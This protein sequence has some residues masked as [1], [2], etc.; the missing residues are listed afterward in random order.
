[1]SGFPNIS[2]RLHRRPRK[3]RPNE[4]VSRSWGAPAW[5]H[6]LALSL[7]LSLLV[8]V[9]PALGASMARPVKIGWLS[10]FSIS[11]PMSL[12]MVDG[13]EKLGYRK[14]D[15]FVLGTISVDER[16][17]ELPGAAR[18]LIQLA[19]DILVG[20]NIAAAALLGMSPRQPIFFVVPFDPVQAGLVPSYNRPGGKVTGVALLHTALIPKSLE[21]FLALVPGMKRVLVPYDK[22][23]MEERT[24]V[25]RQS[26]HAQARTAGVEL[27]FLPLGSVAQAREALKELKGY[28]V[29]GVLTLS[30]IHFNEALVVES[31][32]REKIPM[33][34]QTNFF[35]ERGALAHYGAD[36]YGAGRQLA[37]LVGKV[38][39]GEDLANI[40]VEVHN[41]VQF[42]VN[43]RTAKRL[44]IK[45]PPRVLYR[46][47][48][49]IR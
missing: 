25:T 45:I 31:A 36:L 44:G 42:V 22:K 32:S 27:V 47:D 7:A 11:T 12:G 18:R 26:L 49:I 23:E 28:R 2:R 21:L 15:D 1:M 19:P 9:Q 40:P 34:A 46:A 3:W 38:M 20:D 10:M 37:R 8:A 33:M 35:A 48:R 5:T 43:L 14:D 24:S 39:E 16:H 13:L 4:G 6:L 29:D 30:N 17:G 41:R